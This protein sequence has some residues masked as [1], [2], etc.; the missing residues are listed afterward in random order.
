MKT[1]I[2]SANFYYNGTIFKEVE[3]KFDCQCICVHDL[4]TGQII[5]INDKNMINNLQKI[6]QYAKI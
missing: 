5:K 2:K 6:K 1:S 4:L 3:I